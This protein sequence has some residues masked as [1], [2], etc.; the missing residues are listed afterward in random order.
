MFVCR[1][2]MDELVQ[3]LDED[4]EGMQ[5]T[6]YFLQSSLREAKSGDTS[7]TPEIETPCGNDNDSAATEPNLLCTVLRTRLC[8]KCAALCSDQDDTTKCNKST[9]V[10]KVS[11]SSEENTTRTSTLNGVVAVTECSKKSTNNNNDD[12]EITM[13]VVGENDLDLGGADIT[14][15]SGGKRKECDHDEEEE[16]V[17]VDIVGIEDDGGSTNSL[18]CP[19]AT[20]RTKRSVL[21]ESA[22][23]NSGDEIEVDVENSSSPNRP[24]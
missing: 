24:V 17:H 22:P 12:N 8:S 5:S 19:L 7:A 21:L 20:K 9:V 2:E 6:I 16:D 10:L 15:S 14:P 4:V 11:S 1:S 23:V 18:S 3:E 13:D